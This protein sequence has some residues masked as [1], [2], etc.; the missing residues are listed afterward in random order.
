MGPGRDTYPYGASTGGMAMQEEK[1]EEKVEEG[2]EEEMEE[3]EAAQAVEAA[4]FAKL[5]EQQQQEQDRLLAVSLT[6]DQTP[7]RKDERER[8]KKA[9]AS[10]MTVDQV[11][12][13][14]EIQ[15]DFVDKR[16]NGGIVNANQDIP[17]LWVP[18]RDYPGHTFTRSIGDSTSE[19]IGVI[20]E[21]EMTTVE[22]TPQD[23]ILVLASDGVFEFFTN[24]TI[25][26]ICAECENP[27]EACQELL[28]VSYE[29][30]LQFE[31]RIDDMTI[32]VCFL[33]CT[34]TVGPSDTTTQ[35]I[36]TSELVATLDM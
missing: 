7:F 32:I 16:A 11:E 10:V 12:G 21:P 14:R 13:R 25:I 23:E 20:A 17:R 4:T 36:T 35:A 8:V 26:D 28:R 1:E 3:R 2:E 5:P 33:D 30:W 22:L 18:D 15:D 31:E 19:K 24:Q 34:E 29:R 27:V 6:H 9:G